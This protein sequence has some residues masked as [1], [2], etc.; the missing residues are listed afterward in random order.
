MT[1]RVVATLSARMSARLASAA[2][3]AACLLLAAGLAR[4]EALLELDVSLDP[5][6]RAFK[7]SARLN[8]AERDF[9][10]LLHESLQVTGASAG[11]RALTADAQTGPAGLRQWRIR[12]ATAGVPLQ[13][14]YAG[15]L[16]PLDTGR[17][18]RGVLQ[19][20]PPMSSP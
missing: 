3:T 17:D 9:R 15:Q 12:G 11:G 4:A 1:A 7:A 13:I 2:L 10:F 6:S 5:A 20:M 16:P 14:D 19:R 8:P 18:H